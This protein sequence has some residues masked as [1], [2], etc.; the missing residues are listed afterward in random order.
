MSLPAGTPEDPPS[1]PVESGARPGSLSACSP[2]SAPLGF[3]QEGRGSQG[4]STHCLEGNT[5]AKRRASS[6][7]SCIVN[8]P[9]CPLPT[10]SVPHLCSKDNHVLRGALPGPTKESAS[11]LRSF[12]SQAPNRGLGPSRVCQEGRASERKESLT[13]QHSHS[14]SPEG[15]HS[16]P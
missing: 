12:Q 7:P 5:E 2:G 9:H 4:D 11:Q 16:I 3:S 10:W 15:H 13:S 6:C 1:L 14:T 8:Q